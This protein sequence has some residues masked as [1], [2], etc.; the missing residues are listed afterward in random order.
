MAVFPVIITNTPP[1][2]ITV[3]MAGGMT[4]TEFK[5]SLGSYVYLVNEI[6]LYSTDGNQVNQIMLFDKYNANGDRIYVNLTPII[7]PFQRSNAFW[8]NTKKE[9]VVLNGL[10]KLNF[11]L[12]ANNTLVMQ[13]VAERKSITGMLDATGQT[14]YQMVSAAMGKKD[15]FENYTEKL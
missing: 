5:N 4:Y 13:L 1:A 10:S 11:T 12:L 7:S 3:T 9:D 14:N 15:L 6:Y 8:L 2:S